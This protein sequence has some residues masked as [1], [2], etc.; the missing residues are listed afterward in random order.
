MTAPSPAIAKVAHTLR[1]S[2]SAP[3]L[4]PT[5]FTKR[6]L[7]GGHSTNNVSLHIGQRIANSQAQSQRRIGFTPLLAR[8]DV[9][10]AEEGGSRTQPRWAPTESARLLTDLLPLL[11]PIRRTKQSRLA[12]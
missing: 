5:R 11:P 3:E 1:R 7:A 12:E 4:R 9:G 8:R 6:F 2:Y 10:A